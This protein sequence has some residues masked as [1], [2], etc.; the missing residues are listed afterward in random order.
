MRQTVQ[1]L[2]RRAHTCRQTVGITN[3]ALRGDV[4]IRKRIETDHFHA[5]TSSYEL[6][7]VCEKA[8]KTA[9]DSTQFTL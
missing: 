3:I 8:N 1:V 6:G 4:Q 5:H 9:L 7:G 2:P